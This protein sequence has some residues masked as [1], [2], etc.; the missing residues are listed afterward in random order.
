MCREMGMHG[1]SGELWCRV[2]L[3]GGGSMFMMEC[4]GTGGR[5]CVKM[6]VVWGE[7]SVCASIMPVGLEGKLSGGEGNRNVCWRGQIC[8]DVC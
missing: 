1:G 7:G 5:E 4:W 2:C 8:G 6:K 3:V